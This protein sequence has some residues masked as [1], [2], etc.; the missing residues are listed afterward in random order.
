MPYFVSVAF[1]YAILGVFYKYILLEMSRHEA[2][3][4]IIYI[5]V[6]VALVAWTWLLIVLVH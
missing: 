3:P 2:L 6:S 4:S 5:V 1:L